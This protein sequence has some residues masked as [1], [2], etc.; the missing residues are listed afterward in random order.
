MTH[1]VAFPNVNVSNLWIPQSTHKNQS[2]YSKSCFREVFVRIAFAF[3]RGEVVL[4]RLPPD[5]TCSVIGNGT[6]DPDAD[7]FA[8]RNRKRFFSNHGKLKKI[9]LLFNL[10]SKRIQRSSFFSDRKCGRSI[11]VNSSMSNHRCFP[12]DV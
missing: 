5:Y 9:N 7:L 1:K 2:K 12:G 4:S 10:F 8:P 11:S 6:A 3:P